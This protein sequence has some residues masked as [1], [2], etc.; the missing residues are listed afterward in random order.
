ML[1]MG[2]SLGMDWCWCS[3]STCS[4]VKQVVLQTAGMVEPV[5]ELFNAVEEFIADDNFFVF[6]DT[7][8]RDHIEFWLEGSFRQ[9]T[10]AVQIG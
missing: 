6:V 3:P 8:S 10:H 4:V 5:F 2:V 9:I 7:S 1:R